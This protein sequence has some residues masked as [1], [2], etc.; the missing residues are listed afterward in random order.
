MKY[1]IHW[2]D[3]IAKLTGL[4]CSFAIP[5]MVIITV[6]IVVMRY[7]FG[8]GSVAWQESVTYLHAS[9]FMLA[10]AYAL[11]TDSH[12]RVDI[13]YRR[14]SPNTQAWIN[15]LGALVFLLPLVLVMII[16]GW[17]YAARSWA[18]KETSIEPDGIPALF[19]LKSLI[20]LSASLLLLQCLAEVLAN[21]LT[22]IDRP[23]ERIRG[24]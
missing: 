13:F 11:K 8:V 6:A 1:A 22:I 4:I 7:G 2:L 18:I 24:K 17:D 9:L 5:F 3:Q 14:F 19:L 16:Y 23:I 12:V 21:A 20:V 10:I 15:A